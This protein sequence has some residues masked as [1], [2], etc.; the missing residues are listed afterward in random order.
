LIQNAL[1]ITS[2][3]L[4]IWNNTKPFDLNQLKMQTPVPVSIASMKQEPIRK[5]GRG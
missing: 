2:L 5:G 4:Q 3:S 1:K